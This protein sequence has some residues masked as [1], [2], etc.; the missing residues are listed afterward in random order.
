MRYWFTFY[1]YTNLHDT[2]RYLYV[3][4]EGEGQDLIPM[5]KGG[6]FLGCKSQMTVE[7]DSSTRVIIRTGP[8]RLNC[9]VTLL[10]T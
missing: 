6:N 7:G 5:L 8:E 4:R 1:K 10:S 9:T 3:L 2:I